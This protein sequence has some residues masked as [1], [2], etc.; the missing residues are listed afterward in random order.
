MSGLSEQGTG[1]QVSGLGWGKEKRGRTKRS[2]ERERGLVSGGKTKLARWQRVT[3]GEQG[4]RTEP[5]HSPVV[6]HFN[7][8]ITG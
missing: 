6:K 1:R 8:F 4:I 7:I 3:L 2:G 5:I